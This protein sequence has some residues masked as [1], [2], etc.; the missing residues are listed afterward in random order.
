MN[1]SGFSRTIFMSAGLAVMLAGQ[2][3]PAQPQPAQTQPGGDNASAKQ[4]ILHDLDTPVSELLGLPKWF[5]FGGQYRGRLMEDSAVG[6]VPGSGD[7]YYLERVRF[8]FVVRPEPWLRFTAQI[9]DSRNFFYGDRPRPAKTWDP[10]DL[11][12]GFVELGKQESNGLYIKAGRQ[13]IG[14]GSKRLIGPGE[15][16]NAGGP[17]DAV[18][19]FVRVP[20]VVMEFTALSPMAVDPT[21]FDRH[22][23]GEHLYYTYES[24]TKLI[25]KAAVEPYYMVRTQVHVKGERGD[26]GN[27]TLSTAGFRVIG[28][29]PSRVDYTGE[30][31]WQFGSYASDRVSAVAGSYAA[32]WTITAAKWKPRVSAEFDH[33]SGDHAQ[34]DGTRGTFDSLYA[35]HG[36]YT[37][38]L[39][40]QV[41]WR[42]IRSARAGFDFAATRKLNLR[43]DFLE[44]Y[45]ASTQD[46][47]YTSGGVLKVLNRNATSRHIGSEADFLATYQF[48]KTLLVTAGF[49]H[50]F[51]GEFLKQS[52]KGASYSCP[53]LM[54]TKNF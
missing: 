27:S 47:L 41:G 13:E 1:F 53:F 24:F 46:G 40:D 48:S 20:G 29:L 36:L 7:T 32:G 26:F 10:W 51:P 45:L 28:L 31:A 16:I 43:T 35:G 4:S 30:I 42:N 34:K 25:R 6:F 52:T 5:Q 21:R 8:N 22:I 44:D 23:P 3:Q 2:T 14:L 38:G 11:R 17:M 54:W 19:T 33:A 18:R 49:S 12:Q 50:L 9:Q 39:A 37:Y 15:W